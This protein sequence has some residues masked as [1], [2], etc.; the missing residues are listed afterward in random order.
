M[1]PQR[2]VGDLGGGLDGLDFPAQAVGFHLDRLGDGEGTALVLLGEL[3][4]VAALGRAR[5]RKGRAHVVVPLPVALVIDADAA[6]IA[7]D[8]AAGLREQVH[9]A[10][11]EEH[12]P[13]VAGVALDVDVGLVVLQPPRLNVR[14]V[15][16]QLLGHASS[17]LRAKIDRFPDL[18]LQPRPRVRNMPTKSSGE[19]VA[20]LSASPETGLGRTPISPRA[21][22]YIRLKGQRIW[23]I[24]R[25]PCGTVGLKAWGAS[26]TARKPLRRIA[27]MRQ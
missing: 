23:A 3:D 9:A 8:V 27:T 26:P 4:G 11:L 19:K 7:G 20:H 14:Q 17:P 5:K 13:D 21:V 10:S 22:P 6:D 25:G 18:T 1:H 16:Q 2:S 12:R 24:V 15:A